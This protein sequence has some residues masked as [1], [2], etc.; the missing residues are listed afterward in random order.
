MP[1]KKPTD[2][3]VEKPP[4]LYVSLGYNRLVDSEKVFDLITRVPG[5]P[6]LIA[7]YTSLKATGPTRVH[8]TERQIR[9]ILFLQLMAA[10]GD[11]QAILQ[12]KAIDKLIRPA[13]YELPFTK[14]R[15]IINSYETSPPLARGW[16]L[17]RLMSDLS[18][19]VEPLNKDRAYTFDKPIAIR[20]NARPWYDDLLDLARKHLKRN[21]TLQSLAINIYLERLQKEGITDEGDAITEKTLRRDLARVRDWERMASDDEKLRRRLLRGPSFGA[22]SITWCE[23]SE[24]WK[25]R[26]KKR[27]QSQKTTKETGSKNHNKMG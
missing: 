7:G 9:E 14:I 24:G 26:R 25:K 10:Q 4:T 5:F 18:T 23:F 17:R 21:T 19:M 11:E 2:P 8:D 1:K 13:V 20:K 12:L 15:E 27:T 22:D 6:L 3:T 16:E